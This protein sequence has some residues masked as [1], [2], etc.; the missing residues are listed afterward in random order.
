MT[1]PETGNFTL[2][3]ALSVIGFGVAIPAGLVA[4]RAAQVAITR[5]IRRMGVGSITLRARERTWE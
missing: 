1:N 4:L 5:A 3:Y 2:T